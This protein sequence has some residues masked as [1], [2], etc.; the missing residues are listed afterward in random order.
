MKMKKTVDSLT[1][2]YLPPR[3]C[4]YPPLPRFFPPINVVAKE[5]A[6]QRSHIGNDVHEAFHR[7][8]SVGICVR[9]P[10]ILC[11]MDQKPP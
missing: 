1:F 11:G 7:V 9:N 5:K 2:N 8:L 4:R 6:R 3:D 10:H